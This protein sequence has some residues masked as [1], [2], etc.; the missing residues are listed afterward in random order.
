MLPHTY[1]RDPLGTFQLE[2]HDFTR[3]G[4]AIAGLG[5][6]TVIIQEGG[7]AV[8]AIGANVATFLAK[9]G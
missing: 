4:A 5:L 7:Y 9:L 2:R 6:P 8:D 1:L 3:A